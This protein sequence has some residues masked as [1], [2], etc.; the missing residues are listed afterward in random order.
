MLLLFVAAVAV[1]ATFAVVVDNLII[2]ATVA[3]GPFCCYIHIILTTATVVATHFRSCWQLLLLLL[4]IFI[5]F[6][7]ATSH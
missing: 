5:S 3:I 1:A 7:M 2:I 6:T 4:A